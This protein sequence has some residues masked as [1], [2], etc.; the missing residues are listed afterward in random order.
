MERNNTTIIE[1]VRRFAEK[2]ISIPSIANSPQGLRDVL[3]IAKMELPGFVVEEFE[4]NGI[5]S[6][7]ITNQNTKTRKFKIILNAHLDVVPPKNTTSLKKRGDF[8][9]EGSTI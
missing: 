8:T 9:G 2:L 1:N 7:L 5:P 4:S 3:D 6:M